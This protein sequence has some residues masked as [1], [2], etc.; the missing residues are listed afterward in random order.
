M[1]YGIALGLVA[2]F[3]ASAAIAEGLP[4]QSKLNKMGLG[5]MQVASDQA[6]EQVRGKA[7][8]KII[9]TWQ[10]AAGEK[11]IRTIDANGAPQIE[12]DPANFVAH[13]L[14]NGAGIVTD[15]L[16]L[17]N[18]NLSSSF[19]VPFQIDHVADAFHQQDI[20]DST[21]NLAFSEISA[22]TNSFSTRFIRAPG[23]V[24]IP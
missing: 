13:D 11:A 1:K 7:F 15:G 18:G 23:P 8:F 17:G 4:S 12:I 24:V 20:F 16:P 6:G 10:A 22:S 9:Y 14:N 2:T 3:V 5:S 19:D 21:L